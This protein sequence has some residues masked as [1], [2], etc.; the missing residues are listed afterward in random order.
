M[1][2]D[3]YLKALAEFN[4]VNGELM[5]IGNSLVEVGNALRG[6]PEHF[7][8]SNSQGPG[9]P[10]AATLSRQ[11]KSFDANQWPSEVSI[12]KLLEQW[13]SAKSALAAAWSAVPT[14][15][16]EGLKPPPMSVVRNVV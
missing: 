10:M 1:S 5:R 4:R 2:A 6:D 11:S 7:I 12:M 14:D 13:H 16:R 3:A 8:F 9:L 15:M